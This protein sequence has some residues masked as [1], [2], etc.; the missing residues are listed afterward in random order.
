MNVLAVFSGA[1]IVL[2]SLLAFRQN[3]LK[4]RLAYSTVGHLSYIILGLALLSPYAW[5]GSLLHIVNH[6]VMKITLFFCAGAIYVKTHRENVS[7]LKGIGRQM[8]FN[9]GA[10]ALA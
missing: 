2:A 1:T 10:F 7:D 5:S 8:P 9:M 4:L 3:N 6:A